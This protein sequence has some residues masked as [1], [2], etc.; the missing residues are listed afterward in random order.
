M[1]DRQAFLPGMPLPVPQL[2]KGGGALSGHLV[3]AKRNETFCFRPFNH[4]YAR[5]AHIFD[6]PE[7]PGKYVFFCRISP[8]P[9]D[10]AGTAAWARPLSLLPLVH[11]DEEI[12]QR[13]GPFSLLQKAYKVALSDE[14]DKPAHKL[15]MLFRRLRR[16]YKHE[17]GMRRASVQA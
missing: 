6:Y 5:L 4:I 8:L 7:K 10:Q 17:D 16:R 1:R 12:V 14:F 2:Q 3:E 13:R 9:G 15:H 11:F